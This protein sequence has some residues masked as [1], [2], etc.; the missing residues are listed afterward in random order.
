M[1]VGE[2]GRRPRG[3]LPVSQHPGPDESQ[4]PVSRCPAINSS[5]KLSL[6]AKRDARG[7]PLMALL[8]RARRK[9]CQDRFGCNEGA[10]K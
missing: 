3:A 9:S 6:G 5:L 10:S 8:S 4:R 1:Q 2:G 7:L